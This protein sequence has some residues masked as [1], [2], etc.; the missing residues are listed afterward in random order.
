MQLSPGPFE[1]IQNPSEYAKYAFDPITALPLGCGH[2]F[3][4][5]S[6]TRDLGLNE[7]TLSPAH[8]VRVLKSQHPFYFSD[9]RKNVR[10]HGWASV[11]ASHKSISL[12]EGF[13]HAGSIAAANAARDTAHFVARLGQS[14]RLQKGREWR[15]TRE[16]QAMLM[17]VAIHHWSRNSDPHTHAHFF[18]S[19]MLCCEDKWQLPQMHYVFRHARLVA[20]L[21]ESSLRWNLIEQGYETEQVRIGDHL[22]SRV[23][24]IPDSI[25][26]RFSTRT[27]DISEFRLPA[28]ESILNERAASKLANYLTR[29]NKQSSSEEQKVQQYHAQLSPDEL[30]SIHQLVEAAERRRESGI[31]VPDDHDLEARLIRAIDS[32]CA[33]QRSA[34]DA[35]VL[36]ELFETPG[37]PLPPL[38][39]VDHLATLRAGGPRAPR[40]HYIQGRHDLSQTSPVHVAQV[41][42][43]VVVDQ[44]ECHA[45]FGHRGGPL[46]IV[47]PQTLAKRIDLVRRADPP[48]KGGRWNTCKKLI[49]L[50]AF[51]KP[52]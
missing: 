21:F 10:C 33:K 46:G 35:D 15:A 36:S 20:Q 19:P 25:C 44:G 23:V 18:V 28:A 30:R 27:K 12:L 29:S 3:W 32:A 9:L 50:R 31:I 51:D 52:P 45:V 37:C 48:H 26:S 14:A 1:R 8:L 6:L 7:L 16:E 17:A 24:G 49:L 43:P 42:S 4:V 47:S 13:C 38:A 22:H 11:W 5:G 34:T 39:A 2:A 41:S 40:N